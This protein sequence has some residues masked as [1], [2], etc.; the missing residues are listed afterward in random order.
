NY[1]VISGKHLFATQLSS[2][3]KRLHELKLIGSEDMTHKVVKPG[4]VNLVPQPAPGR[5]DLSRRNIIIR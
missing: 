1:V 5:V 4:L 2:F 3:M